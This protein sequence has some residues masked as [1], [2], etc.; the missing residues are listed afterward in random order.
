MTS[1][2]AEPLLETAAL[3]Y[4]EGC[5]YIQE[6][7]LP[8]QW[9]ERG[10][11]WQE[12]WNSEFA[13]F[14]ASCDG[15][16]LLASKV[17]GVERP[18]DI[19]DIVERVFTHHLCKILDDN[20]PVDEPRKDRTRTT[21][22]RT[23]LKLAK[24][25]QTTAVLEQ[26]GF[27]D[28]TGEESTVKLVETACQTLLEIAE[29]SDEFWPAITTQDN[30]RILSATAEGLVALIPY[31]RRE[32]TEPR[33]RQVLRSGAKVVGKQLASR[34]DRQVPLLTW[35]LS[36]LWEYLDGS[37]QVQAIQLITDRIPF[38]PQLPEDPLVD[39]F[40]GPLGVGDYYHLDP[41]FLGSVGLLR[42]IHRGAASTEF[43]REVLPIVFRVIDRVQNLGGCYS[44]ESPP[45]QSTFWQHYQA[46]NLLGEYVRLASEAPEIRGMNLMYIEPRHFH[47]IRTRTNTKLGVVLMPLGEEWSGDVFEAFKD[48]CEAKGFEAWRSDLDFGD[49]QI[50][51]TIWSKINSASFIVA[52]CTGQNPNVFYE[53]GMAHTI[54]KPVFIC[55]QT[56]ED[57]PFDIAAIRSYAYGN[58]IGSNLKVLKDVLM[59]FLEAIA[60]E[61]DESIPTKRTKEG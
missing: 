45:H 44:Y 29:V 11:G 25:L 9:S 31:A 61:G 6:R 20:V 40:E 23:T 57:I 3:S 7:L 41:R 16:C 28:L 4:S 36:H 26:S 1:I 55:A 50:M 56:R 34:P 58:P 38:L 15:L 12:H 49:D 27:K 19:S 60:A 43:L 52:D 53:L 5:R 33:G 47:P 37:N 17:P 35:S 42:L 2:A 39:F 54:G 51:Q 32:S 24:F 13:G 46:M 30:H 8:S 18:T 14:Y 10:C 48:T 59:K 21:S 22:T